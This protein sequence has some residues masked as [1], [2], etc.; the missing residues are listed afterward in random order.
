MNAAIQGN[1]WLTFSIVYVQHC[2]GRAGGGDWSGRGRGAAPGRG[3]GGVAPA[4]VTPC[5]VNGLVLCTS[6]MYVISDL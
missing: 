4:P 3:R 1:V 5:R 6:Y 2:T